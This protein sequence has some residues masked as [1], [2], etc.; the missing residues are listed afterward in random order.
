LEI[1]KPRLKA[2]EKKKK[3]IKSFRKEVGQ[4]WQE[5]KWLEHMQQFWAISGSDRRKGEKFCAKRV[6]NNSCKVR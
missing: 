6:L 3:K 4:S 2:K 1:H 5:I